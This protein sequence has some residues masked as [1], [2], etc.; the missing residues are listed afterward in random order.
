MT[1]AIIFAG[2]VATM[3]AL[4][5]IPRAW[6]VGVQAREAIRLEIAKVERQRSDVDAAELARE[7]AETHAAA[8]DKRLADLVDEVR[9]VES[10]MGMMRRGR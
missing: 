7:I 8:F 1:A 6:L 9:A 2:F 5:A 10:Q 3:Y 4:Y